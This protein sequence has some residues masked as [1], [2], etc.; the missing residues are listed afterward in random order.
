MTTHYKIC[1]IQWLFVKTGKYTASG[2]VI[3]RSNNSG[4]YFL[5]LSSM[6]VIEVFT[7][8]SDAKEYAQQIH[9]QKIARNA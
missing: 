2:F 5:M 1:P 6:E 7:N 8:L 3:E 9:E 4:K